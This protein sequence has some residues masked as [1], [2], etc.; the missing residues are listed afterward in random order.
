M[1]MKM[2]SSIDEHI[3][4]LPEERREALEKIR[5]IVHNVCPDATET[6]RYG[7]PTF[8]LNGKNLLHFAGYENHI[9]F[10]PSPNGM[11]KFEKELKPYAS[12]KGTAQFP[13]DKPLPIDLIKKIIRFRLEE[14]SKD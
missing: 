12:G 5:K 9:G 13:W 4:S 7:I 11:K 2:Y 3:D 10:Y 8:Q 6:I 14:I 1:A